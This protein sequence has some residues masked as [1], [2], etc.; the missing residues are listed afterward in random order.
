MTAGEIP[1]GVA[2]LWDI[3]AMGG[4]LCE[5]CSARGRP[6]H[7]DYLREVLRGTPLRAEDVLEA[8][9]KYAYPDYEENA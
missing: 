5:P 6:P 2:I 1:E 3:D 4:L 8:I 9:A 7:Y